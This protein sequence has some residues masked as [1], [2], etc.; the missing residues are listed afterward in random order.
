MLMSRSPRVGCLL[1]QTLYADRRVFGVDVTIEYPF[2]AADSRE[3]A[4]VRQ[5]IL[6]ECWDDA[7]IAQIAHF[8]ERY[9]RQVWMMAAVDALIV[10]P[11]LWKRSKGLA[12]LSFACAT[13][14]EFDRTVERAKIQGTWVWDQV[15]RLRINVGNNVL[16]QEWYR[17][18]LRST[19]PGEWWS[20]F[21]IVRRCG[22]ERFWTWRGQIEAEDGTANLTVKL[23]YLAVNGDD[24]EKE[25]NRAAGRQ[26]TFCGLDVEH[27]KILPFDR[28][29]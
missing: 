9:G 2:A 29:R 15:A 16:A 22:D 23:A 1:W 8:C 7:K 5:G 14:D 20:A 25:L 3:V 26:K 4:D 10:D 24:I 13:K 18:F 6:E 19:D 21:Q 11:L 28:E 12:L 27:V 17:R